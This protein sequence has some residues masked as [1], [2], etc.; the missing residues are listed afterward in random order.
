MKFMILAI[1][2]LLAASGSLFAQNRKVSVW[3]RGVTYEIFVQS[4]ADSNV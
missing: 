2:W 4:F 3:P 1:I